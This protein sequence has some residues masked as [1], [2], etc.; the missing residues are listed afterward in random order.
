MNRSHPKTPNAILLLR[1]IAKTPANGFDFF[2]PAEA[3]IEDEPDQADDQ[4]G[5]NHQIVAFAR[6]TR[7]DHQVAQAG[8]YRDHLGGDDYQ[9]GDA[10]G[11]AQTDNDFWQRGREDN[12]G[13][14]PGWPE[15]EVASGKTEHGGHVGYAVDAGY[16]DGK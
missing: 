15:T 9:P 14:Q 8:I 11:D 3:A 6:V 2:E 13:K 16:D 5:G 1:L 10:E 7:I 4:H 12:P